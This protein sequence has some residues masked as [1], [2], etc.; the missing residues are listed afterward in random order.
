MGGGSP[1][2][3]PAWVKGG[4]PPLPVALDPV[5]RASSLVLPVP[6]LGR[7]EIAALIAAVANEFQKLR[8]R[9]RRPGNVKGL[10]FDPV[11]PFFVVEMKSGVS[12]RTE[13]KF[14]AGQLDVS[15]HRA[16]PCIVSVKRIRIA[17]RLPRIVKGF[18]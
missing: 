17:E 14:F 5:A 13:Q 16:L 15:L 8:I 9:D 7:P 4:P 3:R 6:A 12:R 2:R 18:R 11:R 1:A 10:E